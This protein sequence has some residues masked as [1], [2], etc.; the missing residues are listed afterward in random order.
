LFCFQNLRISVG[1]EK[2]CGAIYSSVR[3]PLSETAGERFF[4][5]AADRQTVRSLGQRGCA[6]FTVTGGKA[7]RFETGQA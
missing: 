1:D 3:V 7:S 5:G 4:A 2:A 6:G